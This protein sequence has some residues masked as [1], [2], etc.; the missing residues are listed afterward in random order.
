M[1]SI[2]RSEAAEKNVLGDA[3]ISVY[4]SWLIKWQDLHANTTGDRIGGFGS[5][6]EVAELD[7]T[8]RARSAQGIPAHRHSVYPDPLERLVAHNHI[9]ASGAWALQRRSRQARARA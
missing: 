9:F 4:P 6:T 2:D 5:R 1:G 8:A 3:P 7:D